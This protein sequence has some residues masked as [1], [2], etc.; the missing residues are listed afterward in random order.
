[1]VSNVRNPAVFAL[2]GSSS[3]RDRSHAWIRVARHFRAAPEHVFD[4][5]LDPRIAG[6]WLFATALR[7]MAQVNIDARAG[8]S[9][10]LLERCSGVDIEHT[11]DYLEVD[12]PRR[13][14]FTLR[15]PQI[16]RVSADFVSLHAGCELV[17]AHRLPQEVATVMRNRWTGMLYGLGLMLARRGKAAAVV[18]LPAAP[19]SHATT[20]PASRTWD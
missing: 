18:R 12:R 16:S 2:R 6:Q 7:P 19:V 14:V 17:V 8:G 3:R 15:L 4:A 9:F 5:W 13:L 11:G 20:P 1:M 10:S